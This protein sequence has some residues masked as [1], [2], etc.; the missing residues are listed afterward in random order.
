M[1]QIRRNKLTAAEKSVQMTFNRPDYNSD[2]GE[3]K[4]QP[5]YK[6]NIVLP[7]DLTCEHCIFQVC[8]HILPLIVNN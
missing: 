5:L 7:A 4:R 6:F 3:W 2:D 1:P 8:S